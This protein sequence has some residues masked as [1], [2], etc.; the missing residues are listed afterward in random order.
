MSLLI[1]ILAIVREKGNNLSEG[2]L[3]YPPVSVSVGTNKRVKPA[4]P[5]FQ[6]SIL[7]K[8]GEVRVHEQVQRPNI[9]G[10]IA[11][12]DRIG[13]QF[14]GLSYMYKRRYLAGLLGRYASHLLGARFRNSYQTSKNRE[15]DAMSRLCDPARMP[16]NEGTFNDKGHCK[17][18]Q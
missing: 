3:G 2:H 6:Y 16:S 14:V 4:D 10:E 13:L 17:I 12:R 7:K 15:S 9:A 1:A 18:L 5:Y 8:Y 11:P